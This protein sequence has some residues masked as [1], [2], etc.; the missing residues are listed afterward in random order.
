MYIEITILFEVPEQ[1]NET[2]ITLSGAKVM[3]LN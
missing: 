1:Q 3:I 2:T